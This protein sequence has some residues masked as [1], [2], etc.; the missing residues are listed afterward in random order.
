MT[1]KKSKNPR[2][3][4]TRPERKEIKGSKPAEEVEWQ[5]HE[6]YQ[7][8]ESEVQCDDEGTP[9]PGTAWKA[10]M[11]HAEKLMEKRQPTIGHLGVSK[12]H[13]SLSMGRTFGDLYFLF[14]ELRPRIRKA[15]RLD[16]MTQ[17]EWSEFQIEKPLSLEREIQFQ[18]VIA[19]CGRA[20]VLAYLNKDHGFFDELAKVASIDFGVRRK[21]PRTNEEVII[22][23]AVELWHDWQGNP[24]REAVILE[25]ERSGIVIRSKDW[26]GYFK[27]CKLD[28]LKSFNGPGR[29]RNPEPL[30]RFVIENPKGNFTIHRV[31]Q[32][33]GKRLKY[34]AEQE[35]SQR[36]EAEERGEEYIPF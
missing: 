20:M 31:T 35:M 22:E 32:T 33:Q 4:T 6:P 19:E 27:R 24:S 28:F 25:V 10:A 29:P 21:K 2:S 34:A 36:A 18:K 16:E 8:D 5:I 23:R 30:E 3:H 26:P 7:G 15:V 9:R 14:D 11:D 17:T 1:K 12:V 13:R